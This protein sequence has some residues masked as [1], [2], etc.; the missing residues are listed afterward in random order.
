MLDGEGEVLGFESLSST[1][2]EVFLISSNS[3][4]S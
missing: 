2:M 4:P 1:A 3:S